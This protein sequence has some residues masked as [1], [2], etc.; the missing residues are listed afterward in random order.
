MSKARGFFS[1]FL[2][3]LTLVLGAATIALCTHALE[4]EPVIIGESGDPGARAE[5]FLQ[6]AL[7]GD[8]EGAEALLY[9]GGSLGISGTPDDSVA[10]LLFDALQDS[11]SFERT[12][13][14]SENGTQ[15]SVE[16]LVTYLDIPAI[17][18][19]QQE[20]T[21]ARL[22]QLLE[23]A[24]RAEDVQNED[25]SY[26]QDVALRALEEVTASLLENAGEYYVQTRLTLNLVYSENQWMIAADE[27]LFRV[28]SGNA[29]Y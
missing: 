8:A 22:E 21:E 20:A 1:F 15:A 6:K 4:A 28:L 9:S 3:M 19:L 13:P 5:E 26:R 17:S 2:L 11:Y 16:F 24:G 29:A 12:G 10:K 25:G 23:Q 18:A 27:A 7:G 14:V